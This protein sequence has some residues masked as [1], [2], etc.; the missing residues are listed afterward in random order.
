MLSGE[1]GWERGNPKGH[2]Y[3]MGREETATLLE[4]P[5][6][7]LLDTEAG[8]DPNSEIGWTR[9]KQ[10]VAD[11]SRGISHSPLHHLHTYDA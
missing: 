8:S 5:A 11:A 7:L 9:H 3:F 4:G 1:R 10:T 2:C 6:T